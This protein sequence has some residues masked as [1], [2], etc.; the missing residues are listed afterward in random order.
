MQLAK[1]E[2][3]ICSG[4]ESCPARKACPTK[5]LFQMDPGEVVTVNGSICRGCGVCISA[6]PE[7]AIR[8]RQV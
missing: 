2:T 5:A 4:H 8:L 1:V 7:K 3:D 6:C